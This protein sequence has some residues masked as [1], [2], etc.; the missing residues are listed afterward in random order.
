MG[1]SRSA[2]RRAAVLAVVIF[3]ISSSPTAAQ[4]RPALSG[5]WEL[6]TA[7]S[8]LRPTKWNNLALSVEHQEPRITIVVTLKYPQGPDYSYQ[9]PLTTDGRPASVDMVKNIRVYRSRW[10]GS[11]L[12]IKWNEDGDRTE[13]WSVSNDAK[14]LTITGSA[15]LTNGGTE[16]WKYVM[17]RK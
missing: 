11:K 13:V 8:Q 10:I 2:R 14:M 17:E 12:S 5:R 16:S 3:L 6:N 15:K 7:Q 4:K 9:I 1:N